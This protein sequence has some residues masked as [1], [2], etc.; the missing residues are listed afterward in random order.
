MKTPRNSTSKHGA[1]S[2]RVR[3][4]DSTPD[5]SPKKAERPERKKG[6]GSELPPNENIRKHADEAYGDTEIPERKPGT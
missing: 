5:A 3:P 6:D 1:A 2:S 4:K